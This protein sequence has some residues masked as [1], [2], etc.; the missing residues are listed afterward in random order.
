MCEAVLLILV[1]VTRYEVVQ[2]SVWSAFY[3]HI[4]GRREEEG[5]RGRRKGEEEG[6]GGKGRMGKRARKTG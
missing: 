4:A 1:N 5:G 6:G 2:H 3:Y